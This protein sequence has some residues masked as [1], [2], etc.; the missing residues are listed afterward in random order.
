[1]DC[2]TNSPL[3]DEQI[4]DYLDN[5]A[6]PDVIHHVE[7]CP[8]CARRVQQAAR[9]LPT[10]AYHLYRIECP[11]SDHLTNYHFDILDAEQTAVIKKHLKLCHYCQEELQEL[12]NFLENPRQ[13][14]LSNISR[15]DDQTAAP[16]VFAMLTTP[17]QPS[18]RAYRGDISGALVRLTFETERD[19]IFLDLEPVPQ[20]YKLNGTILDPDDQDIWANISLEIWQSGTLIATLDTDDFGGFEYL[21]KTHGTIDLR[22]IGPNAT[23]IITDIEVKD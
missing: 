7:I 9:V 1:M 6:S 13:P 2:V 15:I 8:Y 5:M 18:L 21:L 23:I 19:T 10:L 12:K 14:D 22:F 11:S 20:G 17:A 16:V 3:S 4:N